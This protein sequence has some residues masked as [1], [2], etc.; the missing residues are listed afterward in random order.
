M[1]GVQETPARLFIARAI[2]AFDVAVVAGR[3]QTGSSA[4]STKRFVVRS[5][6]RGG[7]YHHD[8]TASA[9]LTCTGVSC[10]HAR[11]AIFVANPGRRWMVRMQSTTLNRG[12]KH[13][14]S[15]SHYCSSLPVGT[16]ELN[17]GCDSKANSQRL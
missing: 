2:R 15:G 5:L 17:Q 6:A 12:A 8:S 16:L 1:M 10:Y 9:V 3:R 13:N 7:R 14:V 11:D 4:T